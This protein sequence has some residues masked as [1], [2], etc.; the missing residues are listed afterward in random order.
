MKIARLLILCAAMIPWAL[1]SALA[2]DGKKLSVQIEGGAVWQTRNDVRIPNNSGTEF[3]L[4]DALGKGPF[5]AYRVEAA[6]DVNERH[7]FRFVLAPLSIEDT[8]VLDR[9]VLFAGAAFQPGT[10]TL[11]SYRFS[12]ARFTYRYRFYR[13][14]TWSWKVGF[15]GFIRNARIALAQGSNAAEDTDVGFVPLAHLSGEA[16][17]SEKWKFLLDFDGIAASQSR[18]FDVAAKLGYA[19]TDHWNVSFGYR[20]LEG[21]ADV[22][23]VFNF[24][25]LHFTV[26]SLRY[27]F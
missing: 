14:N 20:T 19:I 6:F 11:A 5:G 2:Q 26:A 17:I 4:V 7:G 13:G 1:P 8:A 9:E 21:G 10:P 16:R 12:S 22:E 18:A 3:S 15:T 24:A 27:T 23:S 25:W